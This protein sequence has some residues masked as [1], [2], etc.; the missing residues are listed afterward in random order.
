MTLW[1][2]QVYHWNAD[3]SF[4]F[5]QRR[6]EQEGSVNNTGLGM[7]SVAMALVLQEDPKGFIV[8]DRTSWVFRGMASPS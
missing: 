3:T 7:V 6:K 1:S 4:R 5:K 2:P 8:I